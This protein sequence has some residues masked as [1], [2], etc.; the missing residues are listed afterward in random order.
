MYSNELMILRSAEL[1]QAQEQISRCMFE[2]LGLRSE[3]PV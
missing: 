2:L 3:S 1:R